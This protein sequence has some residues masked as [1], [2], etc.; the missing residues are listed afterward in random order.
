MEVDGT[1][2]V[3]NNCDLSMQ[4]TIE[5]LSPVEKRVDFELPWGDVAPRLDRAYDAL[6]RQVTLKGFRQGKAPRPVLERLYREQVEN[7]VARELIES[8][9]GQAIQEKQLEPVAPPRVDKLEMKKGQP[10]KFS[11]MVEIRANVSP[12][13]YSGVAIEVRPARV[14]DE[15]VD[16][17]IEAR[18]RQLTQFVPTTSREKTNPD[19]MVL[20]EVAG[21]VG[22]HKIKKRTTVVDL[23]DERGGPLPGFAQQLRGI[24][25]NS[26]NLEIKYTIGD[27]VTMRELAGKEVSLRI[28]IKEVRERNVPALDDEFAKKTGEAETLAGLKE[29]LR[30]QL[31][32]AD[33]EAVKSETKQKLVEEI[34]KKNDFP[35]AKAL[36]ARYE[37]AMFERFRMEMMMAGIDLEAGGIDPAGL[38]AELGPKAEREARASVLL[39]AIAERE[40]VTASDADLQKRIAEIA[41]GRKESAKKVRTELEQN[42]RLA[43]VR[44]QLTDEKTLDLLV[45]QAKITEV[46]PAK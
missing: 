22:P 7:D 45:S 42:G 43:G 19:D 40:G 5:D 41:A 11:A 29:K 25:T 36:V 46:D 13:D 31:L 27:D 18:R 23:A 44:R 26:E 39:Q 35:I 12:K 8:S 34:V 38:H 24:A 14:N 30:A 33:K 3:N 16:A 15:Q 4:L 21:R 2:V 17:A 37:Q 20:V 32:E 10:F 6:R 9:L 1:A 28:S